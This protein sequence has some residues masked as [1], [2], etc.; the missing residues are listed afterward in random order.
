MKDETHSPCVETYMERSE[1]F[2]GSSWVLPFLN[3][4]TR[5]DEQWE[6]SS[7]RVELQMKYI[8]FYR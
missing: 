5:H 4:T 2:K 7:K 3:Y 6:M 1:A 8:L